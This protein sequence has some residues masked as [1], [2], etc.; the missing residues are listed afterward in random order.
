M[1]VSNSNRT[2]R[3]HYMANGFRVLSQGDHVLC[4]VT[5]QRIPLDALRYWNVARQEAYA[6]AEIAMEAMSD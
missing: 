1:L 6:S 2:A 5:G 3:L 4:A